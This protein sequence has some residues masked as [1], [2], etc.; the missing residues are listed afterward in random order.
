MSVVMLLAAA[1]I[2]VTVSDGSDRS[3]NTT[4]WLVLTLGMLFT[5]L[6]YVLLSLGLQFAGVDSDAPT[7]A[8]HL[9]AEP[10]Q[11][12]LLQRWLERARWA[13]FVGGFAGVVAWFLGTQTHGDLL[14][15]GTG[16]IAAGAVLA[17]LHHIRR[18]AGPRTARLDVRTVADYL[19]RTD[20]RR[21]IAVAAAATVTA[22]VGVAS[23]ETRSATWW[24]LGALVALGIARVA[25]HRVA[26]RA[27][28][29]LSPSL[30][31]ADDL[32]R[33]LAIGRGLAR[34][35]TFFALALVARSC[36][37]L[38]PSIDGLAPLLGV[39]AWLCAFVLW[40]Q[41]RRLGLD[42][43]LDGRRGPVIA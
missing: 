13:R 10:E 38:E 25:Q 21:M 31:R 3:T 23:A 36:F 27:R 14:V 9:A 7:I 2:P 12:R 29:A 16:G 15:L 43:L 6:F 18:P 28:P 11:Q 35:F 24:A 1:L 30:T 17:E 42:F 22:L 20:A 4:V 19:T 39:A 8:R 26:T 33:E 40:W 37:A 5:I 41:N 34:P 32:A